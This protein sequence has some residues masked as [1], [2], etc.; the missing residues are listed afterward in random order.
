[1]LYIVDGLEEIH[2]KNN[3]IYYFLIFMFKCLVSKIKI[4]IN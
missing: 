2:I 1:M 4:K 3:K